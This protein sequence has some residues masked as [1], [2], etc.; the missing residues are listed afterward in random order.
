MSLEGSPIRPP[1]D[2]FR[3]VCITP[4]RKVPVVK[5]TELENIFSPFSVVTDLMVEFLISKSTTESSV[6][7]RL[8]EDDRKFCMADL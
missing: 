3:P 7:V 5:I 1:E 2:C 6:I 4:P 8:A